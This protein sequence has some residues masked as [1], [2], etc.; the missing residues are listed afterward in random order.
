MNKIIS[1]ASH[2]TGACYRVSKC[3]EIV[4]EHEKMVRGEGPTVLDERMETMNPDG[5]EIYKFFGIEQADG[6]KSKVI[7]E[8]VKNKVEKRVMML[9]IT[10][11]DDTNLDSAINVKVIPVAAY[12]MNV[13]KFTKGE[14]ND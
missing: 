2:D 5:N 12:S 4:F 13:C 14:L 6:I 3:A 7:L 9:V 10:E 8:C 11:L 1:Q